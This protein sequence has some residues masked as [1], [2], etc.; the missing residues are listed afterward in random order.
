MNLTSDARLGT[1][2]LWRDIR[3]P[4]FARP[5]P[6]LFLDRDGVLIEEKNYIRDPKDVEL[7]SGIGDLIRAA[8]QMGM[9]AVA[10]TNQAGIARG[11]F[12]WPEMILVEDRMTR[13]LLE[14]QVTIDAVFACPFHPDGLSPY[15]AAD[16]PWRK[17]NT[18]MLREARDLL[19][20]DL[21]RSAILGD[22][23]ADLEAGR[24]AGLA[25]GVHVRTGH[26]LAQEEASR[27][28]ASEKFP[29]HVV[30]TPSEAEPLLAA[31]LRISRNG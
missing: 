28:L 23:A 27:S 3:V 21:S 4:R 14:Q 11:Y 24:S 20:L 26:G 16:H 12:D 13:L 15:R 8:R 25:L 19:N 7:V 6:A 18:G 2:L 1:D 22:K 10:I 17:P 9:A 31:A 30:S 5:L 29:V